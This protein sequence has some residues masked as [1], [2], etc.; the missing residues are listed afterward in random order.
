[1]ISTDY[2]SY[3]EA[4]YMYAVKQGF[5][6]N[7]LDKTSIPIVDFI[8]IGM[9]KG[10]NSS[11]RATLSEYIRNSNDI[12]FYRHYHGP[13][14]YYYIIFASLFGRYNEYATRYTSSFILLLASILTIP[15]FLKLESNGFES[16]IG[17][18]LV[19]LLICCNKAGI[20]AT[21][22]ISPHGIYLLFTLISLILLCLWLKT[23]LRKYYFF[24]ILFSALGFLSIEYAI[25][26][27]ITQ[28]VTFII[29][30]RDPC[31]E[32]Q[33]IM[34]YI[35][36]SIVLFSTTIFLLWP[37]G[38][39]KLGIIRNYI[40]FAYYGLIRSNE[41][42]N[43]G[44]F[45]AW[46]IRFQTFLL[47]WILIITSSIIIFVKTKKLGYLFPI[48]IYSTLMIFTTIKNS[49]TIPTYYSSLLLPLLLLVGVAFSYLLRQIHPK[50]YKIIIGVLFSILILGNF[51][52][53]Y[54]KS[55]VKVSSN[56][57]AEL[58]NSVIQTRL[59][60]NHLII[61]RGLTPL[62]NYYDSGQKYSTFSFSDGNAIALKDISE[63]I[64]KSTTTTIISPQ[65]VIEKIL[66]I[67]N[68]HVVNQKT[69]PR[70]FI[71]VTVTTEIDLSEME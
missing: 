5:F 56:S 35:F 20:M 46:L 1:M 64:N 38:V 10:K 21:T 3:D 23:G 65:A 7:Y 25:L 61:D 58:I 32:K 19:S 53:F 8:A 17:S 52:I 70:S 22:Q 69:L 44:F 12:N 24:S 39:I 43:A 2:Y 68:I 71:S 16:L 26:L 28:I 31:I 13:A 49:S 18:L 41:Y 55:S 47:E 27:L 42:G 34:E 29:W 15:L 54:N 33:T 62:L 9:E 57:G 4:D 67:P 48:L 6:V 45:E 30:A 36:Y 59:T 66:A 11:E 50:Q 51:Y 37:G 60:T 14:Y 40:F 63:M